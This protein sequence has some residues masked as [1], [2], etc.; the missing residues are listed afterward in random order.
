[1]DS[2][3]LE[4]GGSAPEEPPGSRAV[5]GSLCTDSQAPGSPS[6]RV[7][8]SPLLPDSVTEAAQMLSVPRRAPGQQLSL[9]ALRR[10]RLDR[11]T[12]R[13]CPEWCQPGETL[14]SRVRF[15]FQPAA[16][17]RVASIWGRLERLNDNKNHPTPKQPSQIHSRLICT[18][19]F[20]HI[21]T[22]TTPPRVNRYQIKQ[23]AL[24]RG[25]WRLQIY[26][27]QVTSERKSTHQRGVRAA[28]VHGGELNK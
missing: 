3:P 24:S 25:G 1:M 8:S 13:P 6:A 12:L 28:S 11:A 7:C 20:F 10:W 27:H 2:N 19:F 4:R 9:P 15:C 14:N 17:A 16:L 22:P 5:T 21:F 23:A 26:H 18:F